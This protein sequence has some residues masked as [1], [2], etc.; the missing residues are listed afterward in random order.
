VT[1]AI[2]WNAHYQCFLI[3]IVTGHKVEKHWY[4]VL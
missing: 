4:G 3:K 1:Q 2:F